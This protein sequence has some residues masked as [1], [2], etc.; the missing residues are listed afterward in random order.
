M[1]EP[2]AAP[3]YD[4]DWAL[5]RLVPDVVRGDACTI[6]VIL[7]ARQADFL[8]LRLR[9]D[10]EAMCGAVEPGLVRRYLEALTR[11]ATGGPGGGPIG[12][13][14]PSERFHWITSTRSTALQ[15]SP[16]HTG[17]AG[18]PAAALDALYAEL[19]APAGA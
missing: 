13:L 1:T 17:R 3:S 18:D 12:L 7:H 11:V 16:V 9:P 2:Q 8:G 14:T 5:I 19:V 4:Y 15:P 10:A 6:G